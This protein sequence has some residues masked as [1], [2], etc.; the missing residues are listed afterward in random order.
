MKEAN[1]EPKSWTN[2]SNN[3]TS[4]LV[5]CQTFLEIALLGFP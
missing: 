5:Y 1:K 2:D 4:D 3:E